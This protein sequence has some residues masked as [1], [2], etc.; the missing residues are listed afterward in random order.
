MVVDVPI[1]IYGRVFVLDHEPFVLLLAVFQFNDHKTAAEFFSI[2]PEFDFT[3]PQLFIGIGLTF[4]LKCSS[5]PHHDSARAV[6][7]FRNVSFE[8]GVV[9][10]MIFGLNRQSLVIRIE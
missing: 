7:A 8:I 9:K 5:I 4:H 10:R 6:V 1:R 2:Q 3:A